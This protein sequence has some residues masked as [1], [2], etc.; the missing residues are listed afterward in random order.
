MTV[1]LR[2]HGKEMFLHKK[3]YIYEDGVS[4]IQSPFLLTGMS[5]LSSDCAS[6]N[7][8]EPALSNTS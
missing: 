2:I 6:M 8:L 3:R 4:L 1:V 7:K 5:R